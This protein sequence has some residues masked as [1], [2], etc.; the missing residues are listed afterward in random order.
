MKLLF[1]KKCSDTFNLRKK[2]KECECGAIG[3]R[4]LDDKNA[5]YYGDKASAF[6]IDNY[7]FQAR[8]MGRVL[9]RE[10]NNMYD[11]IHGNGMIQCWLIRYRNSPNPES[12]SRI[13][14]KAYNVWIK[15]CE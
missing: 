2:H 15:D 7:S 3:G 13:D 12:I 11:Q 14:K 6:A 5:V 10:H 1:C 9:R 8:V 4:Y